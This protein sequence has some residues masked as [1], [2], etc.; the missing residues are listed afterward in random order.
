MPVGDAMWL[1]R[2]RMHVLGRRKKGVLPSIVLSLEGKIDPSLDAE[3]TYDG[4]YSCL[5]TVE[6]SL[7]G[8]DSSASVAA[9]W[10]TPHLVEYQA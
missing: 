8:A 7:A 6:K 10:Q 3:E 5:L 1:Q 9:T 2:L 4:G